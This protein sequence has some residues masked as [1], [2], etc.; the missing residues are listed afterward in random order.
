MAANRSNT[1]SGIQRAR[2]IANQGLSPVQQ[3]QQVAGKLPVAPAPIPTPSQLP[4]AAP[5]GRQVNGK[6]TV[7]ATTPPERPVS[8]GGPLGCG[9]TGADSWGMAKDRN[10]L[11]RRNNPG[12]EPPFIYVNVEIMDDKGLPYL[13]ITPCPNPAYIKQIPPKD[14]PRETGGETPITQSVIS[15]VVDE[16]INNSNEVVEEI[17][18]KQ[19]PVVEPV[20]PIQDIVKPPKPITPT[21]LV[22]EAQAS[23]EKETEIPKINIVNEFNPVINNEVSAVATG[24][25]FVF[26]TTSNITVEVPRTGCMDPD[27]LNYDPEALIEDGSCKYEPPPEE[28]E[29]VG[30]E[31]PPPPPP[32]PLP[33]PVPF[34][35]SHGQIL[36]EIPLEKFELTERTDKDGKFRLPSGVD[37]VASLAYAQHITR[38]AD[39]ESDLIL[40]EVPKELAEKIAAREAVG[41]ELASDTKLTSEEDIPVIGDRQTLSSELKRN[42][43]GVII[44]NPDSSGKLTISLRSEAFPYNQH[45]KT[46]DTEFS[47]LIGKI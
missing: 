45:Q 2:Q 42:Q 7:P 29:P 20:D 12:Q 34:V 25:G 16:I 47:D 21:E 46:I 9:V 15:E 8:Y 44:L 23:C 43:K 33:D 6:T 4:P 19:E 36:F 11:E 35:D 1:Q 14:P 5:V 30:E 3:A 41:G 32:L 10:A 27:A 17:V 40:T 39:Q 22:L 31:E 24:S 37:I 13:T 28:E 26:E 38:T 18:V